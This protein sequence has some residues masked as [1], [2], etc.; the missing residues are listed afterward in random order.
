VRSL[1]VDASVA[2]KWAFPDFV[3][4]LT[5]RADDLF[6]QY[7]GGEIDLVV[8]DLFWAEIANVFWKSVR[9]KKIPGLRA[10]AAL[11]AMV[12]RG[13]QTFS[14]REV[15]S[16]A[17]SIAIQFDRT[18]YDSVYVALAIALQTELITADERLANALAAH[19][20]VKWL[21]SF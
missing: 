16:D 1:V 6:R 18:A 7:V 19:L 8:P 10:E 21:G 2:V 11:Q 15:L 14:S 3:E 12:A 5:D 20:P 17:L 4:P 9:Q 13:F